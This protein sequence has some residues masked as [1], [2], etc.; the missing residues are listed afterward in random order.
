MKAPTSISPRD[1]AIA[2]AFARRLAEQVDPRLFQVT[3]FSLR[4]RE[5]AGEESISTFSWP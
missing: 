1:L 4:V 3:L 5:Y 2:K